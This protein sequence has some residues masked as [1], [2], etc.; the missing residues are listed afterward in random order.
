[1]KI[2]VDIESLRAVVAENEGAAYHAVMQQ[3][4]YQFL[5]QMMRRH[6]GNQSKI[7]AVLG[8][9]RNTLRQKIHKHGLNLEPMDKWQGW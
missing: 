6:Q 2:K 8:I 4:E 1:M 9:N 5:E 3:L 7:A